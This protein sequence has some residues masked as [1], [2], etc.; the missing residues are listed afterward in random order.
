MDE[1]VC[2]LIEAAMQSAKVNLERL[3]EETGIPR[4]TLGRRLKQGHTFTLGELDRVAAALNK[5]LL[6][7]IPDRRARRHIVKAV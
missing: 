4:V 2:Q 3:S 1:M 5:D 7:L 6:D